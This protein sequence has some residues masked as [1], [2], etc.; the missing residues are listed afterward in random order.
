MQILQHVK[1]FILNLNLSNIILDHKYKKY[2]YSHNKLLFLT[3]FINY[4]CLL[5]HS[6]EL[7]L[8][9]TIFHRK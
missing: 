4:P 3:N 7:N 5:N 9:K 2:S 8:I 1:E 6:I